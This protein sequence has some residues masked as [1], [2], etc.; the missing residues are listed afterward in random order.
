MAPVSA[1]PP[2]TR[3]LLVLGRHADC[4][5]L[6]SRLHELAP[7]RRLELHVL[8]PAYARS[9]LRFISSDV[10]EGMRTARE[11]IER[12]LGAL[13]L[14]RQIDAEGEVGEADPLMAIDSALV[15]FEADEIVLVPS[16]DHGQWAEKQLF[17]HA[18]ERFQI[19][20]REIELQEA[21]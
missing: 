3:C 19:P 7:G 9:A 15:G 13:G 6:R 11:R 18:R 20:V 21:A 16:S 17:A 1:D 5:E 14:D 8:A 2:C 10:D 4:P 12:T